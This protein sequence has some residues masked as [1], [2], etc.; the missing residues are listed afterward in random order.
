MAAAE[1]SNQWRAVY[2]HAHQ[3]KGIASLA[4]GNRLQSEMGLS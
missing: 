2:F 3:M 4:G 1:P